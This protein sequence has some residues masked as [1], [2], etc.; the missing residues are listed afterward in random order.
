MW[1]RRHLWR[2]GTTLWLA[3]FHEKCAAHGLYF[4]PWIV[5]ISSAGQ[6]GCATLAVW[7]RDALV[8]PEPMA[9]A[10]LL[11]LVVAA[12]VSQAL[13]RRWVPQWVLAVLCLAAAAWIMSEPP[14]I[15][16]TDLTIGLLAIMVAEVTA[17]DGGRTGTLVTVPALLLVG[18]HWSGDWV[19]FAEVLF[20]L[21]V[22][23][24]MRSQNRTIIAERTAR[25]R[26]GEQ[27]TLA[28]RQR[29]AREIHDLV[30]HSLSVTMLHVTASRRAL[31]DA[32]E[33]PEAA[34]EAIAEAHSAL[35]DAERIGR[36]AMT[37]IRRTVSVLASE[38]SGT[39]ALPGAADL[40]QLVDDA[41]AAG[42]PVAWSVDGDLDRIPPATGLALY[43][44][45][46]ECL[47]NAVRHAPGAPVSAALVV[48]PDAAVL[49]SSN[50]LAAHQGVPTAARGTGEEGGNGLPGIRA[51][52]EQAG[53]RVDIG[54]EGGA[55][56]VRFAV[57]LTPQAITAVDDRGCSVVRAVRS[58]S[59]V[60][61]A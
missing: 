41:V 14:S 40:P 25:R 58:V 6:I 28:E 49:T 10:P 9:L 37:E 24:M 5:L 61:P 17:T 35:V 13:T 46:Q 7:Q 44:V 19:G 57:P 1:P 18:W 26:A 48:G 52:A 11:V 42:L 36:E 29:V 39:Q 3:R 59:G 4:P 31:E 33:H 32:H 43:R 23:M 50:P 22:G 47:A 54:A 38:S 30:G 21:V 34:D 20:G 60:E 55:W 45:T 2:R 12:H 16:A 8:P 51:R 56:R 15:G 53:G 27:A